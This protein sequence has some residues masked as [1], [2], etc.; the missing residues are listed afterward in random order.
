MI[1]FLSCTTTKHFSNLYS[2]LHC[3]VHILWGLKEYCERL[4]GI[5]NPSNLCVHSVLAVTKSQ[6]IFLFLGQNHDKNDCLCLN[7]PKLNTEDGS[8][9]HRKKICFTAMDLR[10]LLLKLKFSL[11]RT[12]FL[13]PSK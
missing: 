4:I 8:L 2:F 11:Y 1:I 6:E 9:L 7:L 3:C 5:Q 13:S 10:N 12:I